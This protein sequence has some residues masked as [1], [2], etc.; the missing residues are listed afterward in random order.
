MFAFYLNS[1]SKEME[2]ENTQKRM[3]CEVHPVRMCITHTSKAAIASKIKSFEIP[4]AERH[5]HYEHLW[6]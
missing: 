3:H 6:A 2:I 5:C 4:S 1:Q